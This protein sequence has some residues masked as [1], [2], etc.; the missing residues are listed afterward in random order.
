MPSRLLC[1]LRGRHVWLY[2]GWGDG[3]VAERRCETCARIELTMVDWGYPG[4]AARL[5]SG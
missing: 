4:G 3:Q 1:W 2:L 5:A